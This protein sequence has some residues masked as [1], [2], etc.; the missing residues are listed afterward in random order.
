MQIQH[1]SEMSRE[2]FPRLL[3]RSVANES[4]ERRGWQWRIAR[5]PEPRM[6][7]CLRRARPMR[8]VAP[9]HCVNELRKL[10]HTRRKPVPR[11]RHLL[12]SAPKVLEPCGGRAQDA[13]HGA[14][15]AWNL[16]DHQLEE[17]DSE[18]EDVAAWVPRAGLPRLR[19]NVAGSA[20]NPPVL[21]DEG[22]RETEVD[23]DG[24]RT[25]E[26]VLPRD[27]DVRLLDVA[28]HHGVVVQIIQARQ[29]LLEDATPPFFAHVNVVVE[30]GLPQLRQISPVVGFVHE[31]EIRAVLE[32]LVSLRDV[33]VVQVLHQPELVHK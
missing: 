19:R 14:V 16:P 24:S 29:A 3:A 21:S 26:G 13:G 7:K 6:P 25:R 17:D 27:H 5:R 18:A 33:L 10:R 32:D 20:A 2:I 1:A 31:V 30:G 28:M 12:R 4:L 22:R 8:A 11:Q 15:R 9:C 23:E